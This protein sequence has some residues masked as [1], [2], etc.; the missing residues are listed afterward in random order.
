MIQR[1]RWL[2]LLAVCFI[3]STPSRCRSEMVDRVVASVNTSVITQSDIQ[4]RIAALAR[5]YSTQG[6]R[7]APRSPSD[8]A[9]ESLEQLIDEQLLIERYNR[10]Y[11]K[12]AA[13]R[14]AERRVDAHIE[15]LKKN[16]GEDQLMARLSEENQSM[17]EFR[18]ALIREQVHQF[19]VRQSR[20]SWID[21]FLLQPMS[22][23]QVEEYIEEHPDLQSE[24][25]GLEIQLILIRVPPEADRSKEAILRA[26]AEK[27]LIKARAG[28]NFDTLVEAHSEHEQSKPDRGV[29]KLASRT[30]PFPEFAP[31]FDIEAGQVYPELLRVPAG[32]AIVKVKNKQSLF[33][34][35]RR[36]MAVEKVEEGL[37]KLRSEATIRYDKE[38]F[39]EPFQEE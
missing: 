4:R 19:L 13:E 39:S 27:I 6:T 24:S 21:E 38:L 9:R 7:A 26:K 23:N 17:E 16:L 34:A 32:F 2:V 22:Q 37:T 18:E 31:V 30:T 5:Y 11:A 28:E 36:A 33:N 14:Y 1:S 12:N 25:G 29:M 3:G 15:E 8:L 10:A 20:E 35:A